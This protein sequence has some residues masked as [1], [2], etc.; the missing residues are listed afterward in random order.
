MH[1]HTRAREHT[2]FQQKSLLHITLTWYSGM[3]YCAYVFV[4]LLFCL[5]VRFSVRSLTL[6]L[7]LIFFFFLP[8]CSTS[9]CFST[10]IWSSRTSSS[11]YSFALNAF[12][13]V[14]YFMLLLFSLLASSYAMATHTHTRS[15]RWKKTRFQTLTDSEWNCRNVKLFM[16]GLAHTHFCLVT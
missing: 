13:A 12:L 4:R 9:C 3:L 2:M 8:S 16:R 1:T 5:F 7:F 10:L 11:K 14:F 6:L 15:A